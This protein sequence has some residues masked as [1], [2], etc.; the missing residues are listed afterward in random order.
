MRLQERRRE[1]PEINLTSLIDVVFLLLIFFMV[2]TTFQRQA[3][4]SIELPDASAEPSEVQD[5]VID[6]S[7]DDQGRMY[8]DGRELD[9]TRLEALAETL[10][11]RADGDT[12]QPVLLNADANARHQDVVRAMDAAARAGLNNLSIATNHQAAEGS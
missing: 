2:T 8:L 12:T 5:E 1:D 10:R 11:L 9:D 6:L 7:I 3:Q 4:L